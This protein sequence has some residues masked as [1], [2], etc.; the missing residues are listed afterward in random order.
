MTRTLQRGGWMKG[1]GMKSTSEIK[2]ILQA[3]TIEELP[4]F[5]KEYSG[6]ERDG[7]R[8]LA[9]TAARRLDESWNDAQT[10]H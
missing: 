3:A 9:E 6:D 1:I 8:K 5:V 4:E 2:R 10:I 7:V